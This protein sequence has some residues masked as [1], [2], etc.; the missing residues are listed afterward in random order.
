MQELRD[1]SGNSKTN[2]LNPLAESFVPMFTELDLT[3]TSI[4]N[5]SGNV[6]DISDDENPHCIL[7]KLKQK[8]SERPVFAHLNINS[9]SSKFEPLTNMIKD[10][11]DFL[12][13]TESKLDDTFPHGQFQIEGYARPIRL[14]RT[15]NG[16]G[17]I[18]FIRDDLTC[19]E[20]EALER[21]TR[22]ETMIN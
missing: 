13:V 21:R 16:G 12:L 4:S 20:L 19:K 11:I 9:I 7:Q 18:I 6:S 3:G 14:D 1:K 2:E 22:M 10:N 5:L 15:R 17:L 8:N